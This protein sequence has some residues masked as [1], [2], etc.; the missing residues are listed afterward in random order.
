MTP[1]GAG[2]VRVERVVV[3]AKHWLSKSVAT[4]EIAANVAQMDLVVPPKVRVLVVA[5]S[6]TFTLDG[7]EW[8]EAHNNKGIAP[9][10]ELWPHSRLESLLA[11]RP[12]LA[13][14]HGLR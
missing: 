3:Q 13:A 10:V 12:A 7:I 4:A 2:G 14:A 11:A 9:H 6:G 5:T 1:D 8:T